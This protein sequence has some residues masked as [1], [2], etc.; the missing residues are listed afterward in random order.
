MRAYRIFG[1]AVL[2]A[3]ALLSLVQVHVKS[4]EEEVETVQLA[5]LS[6]SGVLRADFKSVDFNNGRLWLAMLMAG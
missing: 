2:V 1:G 3:L 5:F 6:V 4:T